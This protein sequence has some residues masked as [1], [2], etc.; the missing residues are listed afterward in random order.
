MKRLNFLLTTMLIAGSTGPAAAQWVESEW[1]TL[2]QVANTN[3]KETFGW[4]AI[5]IGDVSG[6]GVQD[7]VVA[8]PL[9][10]NA[11][12]RIWARSGA[13]GTIL[14]QRVGPFTSSILGY[15]MKARDWN[16][17]GVLDVFAGAPFANGGQVLVYSGDTGATIDTF[18]AGFVPGD[19]FGASLEFGDWDGDGVDDIAIC[20][21]GY[22]VTPL[23]NAG[24]VSIFSGTNGALISTIDGPTIPGG[25]AQFGTGLAFTGDVSAV[26]DGREELVIGRR[27]E[28]FPNGFV[29]V[30]EFDGVTATPL[31]ELTGGMGYMLFADRI[32]GGMDVNGDGFGDFVVGQVVNDVAHVYS[33][34]TGALIHT[35][36]G[37]GD[38]SVTFGTGSMIP[39][40]D[41]DGH[42]D[43][44]L[45]ASRS[46]VGANDSGRVFL[47]SGRTGQVLKTITP[48][49]A[50][51]AMGI[52]AR[53]VGDHDGDGYIDYL[54]SGTGGGTG[55]PP[56]G[57]FF[58][59]GG[60][61]TPLGMSY[62]TSSPN[63]VSPSG[64]QIA[65]FG[66]ANLSANQLRMTAQ[67]VPPLVPGLFFV[68]QQQVSAPFGDGV[69]CVGSP[70][71][72]LGQAAS[73]VNGVASILVD[74]TVFPASQLSPG[75]WYAQ[76]WHRDAAG[77]PAGFNT[78]NGLE[79]VF[80][81]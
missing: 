53:C 15:V 20:S 27:D 34:P 50:D 1:S 38:T 7:I 25:D 64:S 59:V 56:P 46:N 81:P 32:D 66:T 48:S 67:T 60:G 31:Y 72:R 12:G 36:T 14:W 44:A 28:T 51:I 11:A 80:A 4:T 22:D 39:D 41:A 16:G 18:D 33:G 71:F 61:E 8:A 10:L 23:D 47:Y 35:L 45:G 21:L 74:N 37:D 24:R 54:I 69:L 79:L 52:V 73:D 5:S 26:P 30:F 3:T 58:V 70:A 75:S 55:G 57:R 63:S 77:G 29:Q 9:N 13:N 43:I 68:G 65:A 17:D 19:G 78:S 6:D 40:I 76:Y 49:V 42:A 62:C 2:L